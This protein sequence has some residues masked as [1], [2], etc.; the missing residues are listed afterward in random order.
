[1]Q[2]IFAFLTE[3]HDSS[4][5]LTIIFIDHGVIITIAAIHK[6]TKAAEAVGVAIRCLVNVFWIDH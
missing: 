1:M 3:P 5:I 6:A 2:P 4:I